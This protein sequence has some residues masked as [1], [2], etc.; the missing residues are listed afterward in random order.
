MKQSLPLTFNPQLS[1]L[2]T[3]QMENICAGAKMTIAFESEKSFLG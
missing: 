3:F 2:K 1:L